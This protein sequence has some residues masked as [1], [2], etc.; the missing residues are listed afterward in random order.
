M[1]FTSLESMESMDKSEFFP[2]DTIKQELL[3]AG[4]AA[5]DS[6]T[7]GAETAKNTNGTT[8]NSN[9]DYN[10]SANAVCDSAEKQVKETKM[11]ILQSPP[12]DSK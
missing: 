9:G 12:K 10:E 7:N 1:D 5:G 8:D 4:S 6:A 11:L 2:L 3:D